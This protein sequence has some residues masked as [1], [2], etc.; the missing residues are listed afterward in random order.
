MIIDRHP[1]FK[2]SKEFLEWYDGVT[3]WND[4]LDYNDYEHATPHLKDW[5]LKM[6]DIVPPLN[7]KYAPSDDDLGNGRYQEADYTIARDGI[8][9]ALAYSDADEVKAIAFDLA[10][11]NNLSY[12]D[13]SGS[14]ELH[15]FDGSYFQ[16]SRQQAVYDELEERSQRVFKH[17][18]TITTYVVVPLILF[19]LVCMLFWDSW[20]MPVGIAD[21]IILVVFGVWSYKWIER[22]NQD[23]LKEYQQQTERQSEEQEAEISPLLADIAWNFREGLFETQEEFMAALIKYNAEVGG[24]SIVDLLKEKVDCL[25]TET[26]FI[27]FDEDSEEA[28]MYNQPKVHMVAD[29]GRSFTSLEILFK[30]HKELYPLL[31]NSDSIFFEGIHSYQLMNGPTICRVLLGS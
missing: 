18:N 8:Y 26:D 17:R 29:D 13:I 27:L 16:V 12:F 25:G 10:E 15:N 1:R 5:F 21:F 7:G 22:T 28:E 2:N 31:E 19:L 9:M 3:Q 20:G 14:G 30:L 6:K 24:D 23:V 11:K 4:D